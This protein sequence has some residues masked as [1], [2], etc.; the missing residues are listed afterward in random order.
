MFQVSF[1]VCLVVQRLG[2]GTFI[3]KGLGSIPGQGTKIPQDTWHGQKFKKK[4]KFQV[5]LKRMCILLWL[6]EIVH[7]SSISR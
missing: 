7:V 4:K 3:A 5:S 6:V 1:R 2:L